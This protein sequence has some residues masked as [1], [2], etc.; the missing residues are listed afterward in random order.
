MSVTR[1]YFGSADGDEIAEP[2]RSVSPREIIETG[3]GPDDDGC[4]GAS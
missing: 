3:D 2:F 4:P 1:E